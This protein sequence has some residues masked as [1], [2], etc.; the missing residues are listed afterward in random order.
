VTFY[1]AGRAG[2]DGP[3]VESPDGGSTFVEAL[4][5]MTL[6]E[7]AN[8][9]TPRNR[10]QR[11]V[12]R[13]G[14][15]LGNSVA[16]MAT[17]VLTSLLG[18]G[19]WWFA[20]RFFPA[21]VVGSA[22]AAVSA[23]TLISTL[24]MF[25]MGT[26]LI[27]ELPQS[28]EGRGR[29]ISTC[30]LVAA[31]VATVG[32]AIYVILAMVG[33]PGLHSSLG[34]PLGIALLIFAMSLN[35]ATLVLDEGLVGM[36]LG[37]LQLLRNAYFAFSKLAII[38]VLAIAQFRATPTEVL[39]TWVAGIVISL[40]LLAISLRNRGIG[41]IR[42]QLTALRG[43]ARHAF[44]HNLLN[45]SLFLPRISLP[46]VVTAVV[47]IEANA[48]FYTAWMVIAFLS[49]I[50][51]SI[52]T[53]LFAVASGDSAAL[54]ARVRVGLVIA[55]GVGVPVSTGIALF[56]KP[57]MGMFGDGYAHTA[58]SALTILALTYVVGVFRQFFVAISRVRKR[59]RRASFYAVLIGIMELGAAW[60]G[61]HNGGLHGLV[62]WLAGAFVIEGVCMAPTVLLVA[63]APVR[64]AEAKTANASAPAAD[65][66]NEPEQAKRVNAGDRTEAGL[67]AMTAAPRQP[68]ETAVIPRITDAT[69]M[70]PRING[71][72]ATPADETAV[73]P[74]VSAD[75]TTVIPR[76][77]A[78][79]TTVIPRIS[80]DETTVIPRIGADDT[81]V[82]PSLKSAN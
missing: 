24:G 70:I 54:R 81:T 2:A 18:F 20:A 82:I 1:R 32:G 35:A 50:P 29:L 80:G 67:P 42:P 14:E 10:I 52:A 15:F 43:L 9:A 11:V 73:M 57:I 60:I 38:A 62:I 53:T 69:Q 47:S 17:S 49:M 16:L 77:R 41:S 6:Y 31:G 59:V 25:G 58:A 7:S 66:R 5:W 63:F 40:P 78:D 71:N 21:R 46:L 36:M 13:N 65:E 22:S 76:I 45:I 27:S 4:R 75:E 51:G 39:G 19:Y 8:A 3:D 64:A 34:S 28:K 30:V 48:A 72:G 74:S 68:E 12:K 33:I 26:L 55:L 56:A 23:M 61:G 44:D 37:H 79:E